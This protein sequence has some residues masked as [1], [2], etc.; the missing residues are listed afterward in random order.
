M[1]SSSV[2][3]VAPAKSPNTNSSGHTP[4]VTAN[5]SVA[6]TGGGGNHVAEAACGVG[7]CTLKYVW[8]TNPTDKHSH[9]TPT[10]KTV[11]TKEL[12]AG[13]AA[14]NITLTGFNLLGAGA[15]VSRA[16]STWGI[17]ARYGGVDGRGVSLALHSST[18]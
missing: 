9:L 5:V 4:N 15:I 13:A 2:V 8:L 7:Q 12:P 18:R 11:S 17:T 1:S 6:V 3:C 10:I 16:P 14:V